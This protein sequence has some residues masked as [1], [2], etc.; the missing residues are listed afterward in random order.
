MACPNCGYDL[1]GIALREGHRQ[2]PECGTFSAPSPVTL[3]WWLDNPNR[4]WCACVVI[5]ACAGAAWLLVS[6]GFGPNRWVA[7]GTLVLALVCTQVWALS[8]VVPLRNRWGRNFPIALIA[9]LAAAAF[10]AVPLGY[11]FGALLLAIACALVR[12]ILP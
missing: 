10:F 2:C 8:L 11:F 4:V 12:G 5:G 7:L 3:P 9:K 1:V 6:F